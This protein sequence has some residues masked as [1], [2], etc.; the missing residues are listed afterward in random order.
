MPEVKGLE[1]ER[2]A[3]PL[4]DGWHERRE[5]LSQCARY[6]QCVG[7]ARDVPVLVTPLHGHKHL[8]DV[9]P[10]LLLH[11]C[12]YPLASGGH[13]QCLHVGSGWQ[14]VASEVCQPFGI[15]PLLI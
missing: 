6:L 7:G 12:R 9:V 14:F 8:L 13:Q 15:H 2:L 4:W 1:G 5:S 3:E 10:A 11:L